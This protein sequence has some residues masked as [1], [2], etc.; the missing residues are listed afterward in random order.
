[1]IHVKW[2]NLDPHAHSCSLIRNLDILH[3]VFG[4]FIFVVPDSH[5]QANVGP[6]FL[7]ILT[8]SGKRM[9]TILVNRIED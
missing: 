2:T 7:C 4:P 3:T 8:L 1:M 5:I 9:C 6:S